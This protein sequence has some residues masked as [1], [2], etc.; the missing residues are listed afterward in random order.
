M[1]YL[2]HVCDLFNFPFYLITSQVDGE[3][4]FAVE[5]HILATYIPALGDRVALRNHLIRKSD[6]PKVKTK[7]NELFERLKAKML[8]TEDKAPPRSERQASTSLGS[9]VRNKTRKI[10][11]GW[12]HEQKQVRKRKGGGIRSLDV[13]RSLSKNNTLGIAKCLFFPNGMSQVG[14]TQDFT[15]DLLDFKEIP[16]PDDITVNEC[17]K[18]FRTGMNSD[19]LPAYEIHQWFAYRCTT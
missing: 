14:Q 15:V 6:P 3:T 19:V 8:Q 7:R 16:F 9:D 1:K 11:I 18:L 10:E 17:Y 12:V 5:D 2:L 4:I 13:D